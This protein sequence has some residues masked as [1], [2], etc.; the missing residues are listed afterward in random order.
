ML[1]SAQ[2]GKGM[3][4][5]DHELVNISGAVVNVPDPA[6]LVHLRF[7]RFAGC[8]VCD[9][10]L[11]SVVRRHNEFAAAGIR[12]ESS[13]PAGWTGYSKLP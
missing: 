6:R 2:L 11:R 3:T 12:E 1:K 7:R 10:H 9:L 5:G 13:R 8:P 4:L